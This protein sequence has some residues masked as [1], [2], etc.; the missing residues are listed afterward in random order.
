M[1]VTIKG[2]E[3]LLKKLDSLEEIGRVLKPPMVK[4]LALV[5]DDAKTY[6]RKDPTAFTRLATN[7]QRRAYWAKVREDPSI[8]RDGVGYVRSRNLGNRWKQGEIRVTMR[9]IEG[10]LENKTGYGPFVQGAHQQPFHRASEWRT[11]S[12]ILKDNEG[13]IE[14]LF[15]SAIDKELRK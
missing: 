5:E 12:K 8:H 13:K 15:K 11:T 2:L 14:R 1:A 10:R 3:P 7:A 6:P 9:G 4:A